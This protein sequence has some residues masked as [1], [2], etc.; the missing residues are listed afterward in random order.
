MKDL[1]KLHKGAI[2]SLVYIDQEQEVAE[3]CAE[4]T[5]KVAIGFAE[6]TITVV[7]RSLRHKGADSEF[8]GLDEELFDLFLES[9]DYKKLFTK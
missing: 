2:S 3:S 8:I 9:E 4:I 7:K 6:W 1:I 5:K